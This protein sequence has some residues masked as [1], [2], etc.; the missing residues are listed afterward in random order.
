MRIAMWSGPRNLSTAMM[1]AFGNRGDCAV[2]DEPFYA[3]YLAKTG[4]EH[5]MRAEILDSQPR[6]ADVVAASLLGPVPAAKP[7]FYQKHMTQ[8]MIDGVPRAWMREV[9]NVFLIRHPARV[10]ASYAEKRENPTLDDIG[11]RQQAELFDLVTRWG[12]SPVVVESDDI[13][14]DPAA[15]LERLCESLGVPFSPKML[16]WPM[17]GHKDD[18]IWAA[19][20]YGSVWQSTKFAGP[21]GPLPE[22]PATLQPVLDAAMPYYD[23][24]KAQK[25]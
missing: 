13:R 8:H 24:L 1:Y 20:W 22:V 10:I 3:A 15:V 6:D 11:F 23:R 2:V 19:H 25:I 9:T 7:F 16:S 14:S 18:G 17:G 21:E 4:L 12:Q 5:P